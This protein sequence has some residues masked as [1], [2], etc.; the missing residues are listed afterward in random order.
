VLR[1]TQ[2]R[3]FRR[4]MPKLPLFVRCEKCSA[5]FRSAR[6]AWSE[7]TNRAAPCD[8][9]G[10]VMKT[11]AARFPPKAL[12]APGSLL[13]REHVR[14]RLVLP[15]LHR[16]RTVVA[17]AEPLTTSAIPVMSSRSEADRAE[18]HRRTL[19]SAAHA[20]GAAGAQ[21]ATAQRVE[22]GTGTSRVSTPEAA[23]ARAGGIIASRFLSAT[24]HRP[25]PA[26]TA[27]VLTRSTRCT[28]TGGRRRTPP[29]RAGRPRTTRQRLRRCCF[30][31]LL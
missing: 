18:G 26:V 2:H 5:R 27:R 10:A 20:G 13:G 21:S 9:G 16:R 28:S 22:R 12:P 14:A 4:G 3:R 23:R 1:C 25:P 11:A 8:P 17:A 7:A 30:P 31:C 6:A 24:G 19:E 15:P 29:S